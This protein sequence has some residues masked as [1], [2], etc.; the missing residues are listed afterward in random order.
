MPQ[1]RNTVKATINLSTE[2]CQ[3]IAS[4]GMRLLLFCGLSQGMNPY[5]GVDVA[6]PNQIE[7]KVN[8]DDIKANFKGLKNKPGSTK[9]VDVTEKFRTRPPRYDNQVSLTYALTGKR[10]SFIIYM[11]RHIKPDTLTERIKQQNVIPKQKVIDELKKANEDPDIEATSTRMSLKD[12]ISTMRISLPVRSAVCKHIQCFDGSMFLQMMEQAPLWNCPICNKTISF[13]SLCVDKYFEDILRNTPGSIEKVDVEP[14]GEWRVIKEEEDEQPNGTSNKPRAS[15]D[16]DFDDDLIEM[17]E[18]S[19][20]A[21]NGLKSQPSAVRSSVPGSFHTPPLSSREPSVAQSAVSA[22]R[23]G[24]KRPSGA[25][26]DLTLS[27]EEDEQPPRPAK[28][29]Q[30]DSTRSQGNVNISNSYNTPPSIPDRHHDTYQPAQ[31]PQHAP[32]ISFPPSSNAASLQGA[33]TYRPTSYP[34]RQASLQPFEPPAGT[35][36]LGRDTQSPVARSGAP[37]FGA[38]GWSLWQSRP[39]S[40]SQSHTGIQPFSIRPPPSPGGPQSPP[41]GN[42]SGSEGFRL[43]PINQSLGLGDPWG[44][45][46]NNGG[47]GAGGDGGGPEGGWRNSDRGNSYSDSPL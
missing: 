11:V 31:Q 44:S 39:P 40:Q 17:T 43:P 33:D 26:I 16:D 27:D 4:E 18:P 38:A 42:Q 47:G 22:N 15:Y 24:N 30:T 37:R 28:R 45:W 32:P 5:H 7:I 14:T 25:V 9:P 10:Y 20:K 12:P 13:Q 46:Q 6:F 8:G 35:D 34:S 21:V 1:N 36:G 2:Q 3:R 23:A 19:N 41:S 29:L